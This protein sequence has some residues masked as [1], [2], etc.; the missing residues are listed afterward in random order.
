MET[1]AAKRRRT[2]AGACPI[3]L[4]DGP[5]SRPRVCN[6]MFHVECLL[7]WAMVENTC[8]VCR[9]FFNHIM[10]GNGPGIPIEDAVQYD[11]DE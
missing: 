1:R 2:Q 6:H 11:E 4:E 5:A 8:P 9:E 7:Q 10:P 3:C